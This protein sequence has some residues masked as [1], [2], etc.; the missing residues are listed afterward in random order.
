MAQVKPLN[1][2]TKDELE[3]A[4]KP[5]AGGSDPDLRDAIEAEL[6]RLE[7]AAGIQQKR[8]TAA[9]AHAA[10]EE[11]KR[12]KAYVAQTRLENLT[13]AQEKASRAVKLIQSYDRHH[14][15]ACAD[16]H[17]SKDL[18]LEVLAHMNATGNEIMNADTFKWYLELSASNDVHRLNLP[19]R[20]VGFDGG[21][22]TVPQLMEE[23]RAKVTD[24][25][26]RIE[27]QGQAAE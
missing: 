1:E 24:M 18:M 9:S 3:A 21:R 27:F 22:Q 15:N 17:A 11:E 23:T 26:Q 10:A 14:R 20:Q 7:E 12:F 6:A 2:M 5:V 4:Y 25:L 13:S 16:F 8:D 19:I